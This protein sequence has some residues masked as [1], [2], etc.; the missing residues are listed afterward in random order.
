[1]RIRGPVMRKM[2]MMAAAM[3]FTACSMDG[4][5]GAVPIAATRIAYPPIADATKVRPDSVAAFAVSTPTEI[6]RYGPGPRHFGELRVPTGR[7]PFPV[8]IVIH[9]GCFT[10]G[11]AT[12][13]YMAPLSTRLTEAG[14]AT[15]NIDYREIGDVGAGWPG[16]FDDFA[17]AAAELTRLAKRYPLDLKRVG[18][19][20]HSAGMTAVGFLAAG[21]RAVDGITIPKGIPMVRNAVM[22]DGW[23]DLGAAIGFDKQICGTPVMLPLHGGTP[24]D[25]PARYAMTA[26]GAWPYQARVLMVGGGLISPELATKVA[27]EVRAKGGT[28]EIINAPSGSHFGM[29]APGSSDFAVVE[30]RM[31]ALLKRKP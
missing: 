5:P 26:M 20:G 28:I 31:I 3:A 21:P 17:A 11:F 13:A 23:P 12:Q 18:A 15:W 8:A 27:G 7:G 30:P 9:G 1:M 29:V 25:R 2:A 24:F 16:T 14:I 6:V 4:V 19:V 10:K 22:L